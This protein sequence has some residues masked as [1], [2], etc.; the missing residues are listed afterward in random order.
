MADFNQKEKLSNNKM[1][2]ILVSFSQKYHGNFFKILEALQQKER[3][4]DEEIKHYVNNVEEQ[5]VTLLS[6]DFPSSL[7][8]IPSP[9]FVLYYDGDLN[10]M[11]QEGVQVLLPLDEEHYQRC[12]VALKKEDGKVHYCIGVE[13]ENQLS[14]VK[15][16]MLERNPQHDFIDYS[17]IEKLDKSQ[18]R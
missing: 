13:N 1:I 4:T 15:D 18:V 17:T 5:Y 14:F 9:P 16:N 10:L 8:Q 2:Q 3:F 6:D 7:K 12:F 11:H